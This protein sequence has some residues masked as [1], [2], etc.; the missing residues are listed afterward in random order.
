M[1]MKWK[2]GSKWMVGV[3]LLL[4]ALSATAEQARLVTVSQPAKR[5]AKKAAKSAPAASRAQMELAQQMVRNAYALGQGLGPRQRVALMTRLLYT[6]RPDVMAPEKKQWAEELFVLAQQLPTNGA[7]EA[8]S[9]RNAAIATA[10]ARLAVYDADR[11]LELLDSLSSPVQKLGS[12]ADAR[13]MAARLVFAGYMRNHGALGAQTLLAHGQKWSTQGGFP[14]GASATALGKLRPN[15]DAAEDF[16][17]QVLLIF[18]RGQEGLYGVSE[19]ASLLHQAVAMEAIFEDTAEEAGGSIMGQLRTLTENEDVALTPEQKELVVE[20]LN[21]VRVSAPKAYEEARKTSPGLFAVRVERVATV[22]VEAPKVDLGLQVS[23]RELAAAM[24]AGRKPDEL[25][26]VIARGLQL[27]NVKYKAGACA[28]CTS[29]DAQS[30]ALVSLAAFAA[31]M[32]IATQLNSIE[33]PFWR[34][35][36]LAIAGQQVGQPTRVADPTARSVPG[37]EVAEPE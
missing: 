27:M 8:D 25:H 30:W 6:M 23:F 19:F 36:F 10:A 28:E 4:M 35:Y 16:F 20:A 29:P 17:R 1:R 31:P 37:K 21:H 26:Q 22:Q 3:L 11:A 15:E 18:E 13:S 14:Y 24:R 12:Q 33:D 7:V 34:A 32:T 2:V 9:F 5:K